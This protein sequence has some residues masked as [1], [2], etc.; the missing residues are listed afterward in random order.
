MTWELVSSISSTSSLITIPYDF[1]DRLIVVEAICPDSK[2]S[3][4]EA[5][6]LSQVRDIPNVGI[7]KSG[8]RK[9]Y[10]E[11]Q[12]VKF[13]SL[14]PIPYQLEF[15]AREWIPRITLNV[16]ENT[17]PLY[18]ITTTNSPQASGEFT[19]KTV[20]VKNEV[21]KL[22]DINTNRKSASFFNPDTSKSIYLDLVNTVS[23]TNAAFVI[24]PGQSLVMD[25]QWTGEIYG[26]VK[27]GTV[28]VSVREF[29]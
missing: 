7:S 20:P 13:D 24:P 9:I 2:P 3:W 26:I 23:A 15:I 29:L 22:L 11:R 17:M 8:K 5:G 21:T 6:W 27:T 18:P 12:E 25:L 19:S 28:T 4:H 10:L 14:T 1:H 16:W